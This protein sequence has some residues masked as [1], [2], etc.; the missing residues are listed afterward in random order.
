[1][2]ANLAA[3]LE[4]IYIRPSLFKDDFG[5]GQS[6]TI[7]NFTIAIDAELTKDNVPEIGNSLADALFDGIRRSGFNINIKQ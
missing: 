2:F 3:N 5:E 7:D 1:M 4:A 6:I